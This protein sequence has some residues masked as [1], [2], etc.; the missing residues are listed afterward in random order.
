[1]SIRF[2]LEAFSASVVLA[3]IATCAITA[4]TNTRRSHRT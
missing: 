3:T 4:I 2:L 1:M